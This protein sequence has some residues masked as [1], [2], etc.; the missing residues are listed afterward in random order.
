MLPGAGAAKSGYGDRSERAKP[1]HFRP[2][3]ALVEAALP[4]AECL[5]GDA[6]LIGNFTGNFAISGLPRPISLARNCC[7]R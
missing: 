4:A 1:R 5:A 6:V 2:F 7:R 3:L